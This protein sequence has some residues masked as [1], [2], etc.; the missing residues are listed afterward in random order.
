MSNAQPIGSGVFLWRDDL[1]AW[2]KKPDRRY[3]EKSTNRQ[4]LI[5]A[6]AWIAVIAA[7]VLWL[8]PSAEETEERQAA[9]EADPTYASRTACQEFIRQSLVAPST[10]KFVSVSDWPAREL[11][12]GAIRVT[13]T[14][15][16]EN[17]FGAMLRQN[18][19]CEVRKADGYWHLESLAEG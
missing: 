17:G 11:G 9:R 10:A 8:T 12:S 6:A 2:R 1:D 19:I 15:D 7:L 16:A 3:M 4:N 14:L 18:M 5:A 13:A